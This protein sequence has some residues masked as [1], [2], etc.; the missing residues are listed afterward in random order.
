MP[1]VT[2]S[3]QR[4]VKEAVMRLT[5]NEV[6]KVSIE[7]RRNSDKDDHDASIAEEVVDA[8][9]HELEQTAFLNAVGE[10]LN[11]AI[12][13]QVEESRQ[14]LGEYSATEE[15]SSASSDESLAIEGEAERP[16]AISGAEETMRSET[17]DVDD[18]S[19]SKE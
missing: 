4:D 19:D 6:R 18:T 17:E 3:I 9:T 7:V 8:R 1:A 16:A 14:I 10:S 12:E 13:K 11:E 15:A 2:A 5:G